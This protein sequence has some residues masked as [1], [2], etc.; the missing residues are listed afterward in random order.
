MTEVTPNIISIDFL[1]AIAVPISIWDTKKQIEVYNNTV[2]LETFE[3]GLTWTQLQEVTLSNSKGTF[4][5]K[6]KQEGN[7]TTFSLIEIRNHDDFFHLASHDLKEPLRKISTFG[8]RLSKSISN[9]DDKSEVFLNRMMDASQRLSSMLEALLDY[10]RIKKS[11]DPSPTRIKE[12][13]L[14]IAA[15]YGIETNWKQDQQDKER[16]LEKAAFLSV[17]KEILSNTAKFKQERCLSH[18]HINS[19]DTKLFISFEDEGI[20]IPTDQQKEIIKPF[21]KLNGRSAFPG[22]GMGLAIA[23]KTCLAYGGNLQIEALENGV[24][25]TITWPLA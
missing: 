4:D 2:F 18:I 1:N 16:L 6:W 8:E 21:V 14:A 11:E 20:G 23:Q 5:V 22:N 25:A 24:K 9:K 13:I 7:F 15:K 19:T 12:E 10:S 3:D 17:V